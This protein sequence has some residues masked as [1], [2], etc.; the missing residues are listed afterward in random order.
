[1]SGRG[2][3]QLIARRRALGGVTTEPKSRWGALLGRRQLTL[4]I[5]GFNNSE[6]HATD[7]WSETYSSLQRR[8]DDAA[9]DQ[10]VLYYWPGDATRRSATSAPLYFRQ[11]SRAVQC[12][13]SL[14]RYLG[15]LSR[16]SSPLTVRL[17][18]H[19]LGARLALETV[20]QLERAHPHVRVGDVLLLAPA[21]PVGLCAVE[22]GYGPAVRRARKEVV[23]HSRNDSVLRRAF[24]IGQWLARHDPTGGNPEPHPGSHPEAVGYTGQPRPRWSGDRVSCGLRHG[25]YW[26]DNAVVGRISQLLGRSVARPLA[27]RSPPKRGTPERSLPTWV[28]PA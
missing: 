10:M 14:A 27:E 22:A 15:S 3:I 23:M 16:E 1:M 11:V 25:D 19:S 21:V 12:G 20:K 6:P 8:V 13:Q 17:V 4:L 7:V 24:P 5:H 9:L 18:A 28:A 26:N 2:P